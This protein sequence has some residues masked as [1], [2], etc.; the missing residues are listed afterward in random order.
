[1]QESYYCLTARAVVWQDLLSQFVV[2]DLYCKIFT[3]PVHAASLRT[4]KN[5]KASAFDCF[6]L[7]AWEES[8]VLSISDHVSSHGLKLP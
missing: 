4:G 2:E 7:N 6:Q 5:L 8:F 3:S 1:M